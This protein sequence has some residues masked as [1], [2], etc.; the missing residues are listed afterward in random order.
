VTLQLDEADSVPGATAQA[1][2]RSGRDGDSDRDT[3]VSG[4]LSVSFP[5]DS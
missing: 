2:K 4:S 3:L 5:R 1:S